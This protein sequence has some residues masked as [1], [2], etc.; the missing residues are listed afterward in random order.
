MMFNLSSILVCLF[1]EEGVRLLT[2]EAFY[3]SMFVIP[4]LVTYILLNHTFSSIAKP[5]IIFSEKLIYMLPSS[6]VAMCVNILF[7]LWLIPLYGAVG[8]AIATVVA[9]LT[10]SIL[11]FYFAQRLYPLPLQYLKLFGPSVLFLSFLFPIYGLMF[12]KWHILIELTIKILLIG[13]Y[14]LIVI[15]LSLINL[16]RVKEV[17]HKLIKTSY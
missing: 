4:I 14:V 1:A 12:V 2:T 11:L 10:S 13:I 8:A 9:G 7:N 16:G 17:V 15:K 5:Q 6:F 3:P